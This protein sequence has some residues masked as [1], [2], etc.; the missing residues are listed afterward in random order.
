MV[1]MDDIKIYYIPINGMYKIHR[2]KYNKSDQRA[3]IILCISIH[4]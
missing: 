3:K 1:L 2:K 4:K